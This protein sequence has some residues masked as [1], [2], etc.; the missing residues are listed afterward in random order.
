MEN[1]IN[2]IHCSVSQCKYNVSP[3]CM[4]SLD[5]VKIGSHG[6]DAKSSENTDCISF[7]SRENCGS[8]KDNV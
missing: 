5:E 4:C 2:R 3:D 6:Q 7:C 8:W 1:K